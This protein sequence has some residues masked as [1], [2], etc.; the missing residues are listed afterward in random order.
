MFGIYSTVSHQFVFGIKEET[1]KVARDKLWDRI[2]KNALK[3][4]FETRQIQRPKKK[5]SNY[6]MPNSNNY[7]TRIVTGEVR[8]SFVHLLKPQESQY[9]GDPK[10]SLTMLIKKSDNATMSAINGA[11]EAAK[12]KGKAE[13]WNGVIPPVVNVP[14]HDGDG[15]KPSDGMPFG[16]ECH[17]CYVLSAS[18][19][20]DY[21]PKI[22]GPDLQP[23][24][25]ATEVYSGMYGRVALNFNPY[26]S[27]GKKG[28]GC[29]ISTNVMKTRDG[30]PLGASAPEAASDFG[31]P[32]APG[33]PLSNG[34][35]VWNGI[36]NNPAQ[37]S[38]QPQAAPQT[39]QQQPQQRIN[40]I[41]GQPM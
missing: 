30:E 20:I 34:A 28:V 21:P 35:S 18:T 38:Q 33:A 15:V 2:G 12:Q 25:D 24:M 8:F 6:K 31:A 19:S 41:T 26:D 10:F 23:L 1:K 11:V 7:A 14:I 37:A 22:V 5:R 36:P 4:R 39:Y 40:P 17:G 16:A 32:G 29:Y 9:G 27:H 3:W 13:K